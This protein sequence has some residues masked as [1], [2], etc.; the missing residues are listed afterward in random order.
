MKML[1]VR[2]RSFQKLTQFPMLNEVQDPLAFSMN[3][4]LLRAAAFPFHL[5]GEIQQKVD[6]ADPGNT[7][8]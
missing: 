3:A 7:E 8:R 1:K 6:V 4:S 2:L 5:N